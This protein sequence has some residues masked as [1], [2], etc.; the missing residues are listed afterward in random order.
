ALTMMTEFGQKFDAV[1]DP[2]TVVS[3]IPTQL[4]E[5]ALGFVMFLVAWRF[6]KHRHAAGWLFGLYCVMAGIERFI[7]EFMRA[8]D[9]R[10]ALPFGLSTAQGVAVGVFLVGVAIMAVRRNP[11]TPASQ[12]IMPGSGS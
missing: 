4:L 9:D 1:I 2:S 12:G 8:K 7:V 10:F 6:R 5:V 3:V 11:L